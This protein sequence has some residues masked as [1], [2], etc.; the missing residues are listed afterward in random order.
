MKKIWTALF[1]AFVIGLLTTAL[2]LAQEPTPAVPDDAVNAVA[3]QLYCPVCENTPLDVC[4]TQACAEWRELIRE[5]LAQG[6]TETQIK[7]YFV[8]RFGDR[9]LAAPPAKG[10]NWLI[11]LIP[12]VAIAAGIYLLYRALKSLRAVP[13]KPASA[14]PQPVPSGQPAGGKTDDQYID[15]MEE[16]LRKM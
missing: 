4:P 9:V 7:Q 10:L 13:V 12:P 1:L 16:E 5:K 11:Y 8:D 14:P 2:A 6:Q 15:R 3:K